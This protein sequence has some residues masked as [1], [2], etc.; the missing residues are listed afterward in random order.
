MIARRNRSLFIVI[1][2]HRYP[3]PRRLAGRG[4][5]HPA[6]LSRCRVNDLPP[7]TLNGRI[8][9]LEPLGYPHAGGLL[10]AAAYDEIWTYLDEPT[11]QTEADRTALI[12]DALDGQTKGTRLPFA[13]IRQQGSQVQPPATQHRQISRLGLLQHH[14]HR[15]A[16]RPRTTRQRHDTRLEDRG[17]RGGPSPSA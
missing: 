1:W 14:R 3:W 12:S 16:I 2:P 4:P 5:A 7:V 17:K 8:V 10:R 11:P 13:V 9:R 15:M 6:L